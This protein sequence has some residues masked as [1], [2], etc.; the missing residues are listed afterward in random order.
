M[1]LVCFR[2]GPSPRQ[3]RLGAL[4]ADQTSVLDLTA[5]T[6]CR[7]AAGGLP[8]VAAARVAEA[9]T[10]P[11]LGAFV[12][13]GELGLE[14]AR[15][16][17]EWAAHSGAERDPTGE[18]VRYALSEVTRLAAVPEP[19]LIRDFMAFEQHL[20]NI[21][22]R[23]GREIPPEWY[24]IPAYYKG[25]PAAVGADGDDVVIPGYAG[26][27]LDFEFEFAAVIGR[28]GR[29]IDEADA[30]AHVYGYTIYDDFSARGMQS[31]EMAVGLGP[32][33]GKDFDGAHVLGPWLVTADEVPDPYVLS[34]TA[35]VNG[36]EW[37]TGSSADMHWRFEQMIAHASR[38]ETLR[39]LEV[40]GSGTV[41][42]GSAAE[43]GKTLRDG[44]TVELEV[45]RL[46]VLRNTVRATR[47]RH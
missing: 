46:G 21:Y 13:N 9:L 40:F 31:K 29:D 42:G 32:A 41:G 45:E 27:E 47:A 2:T 11:Q 24:E 6:A 36:Q 5:A 35:R 34:L 43:V 16:S 38:A 8:A 18:R 37:T 19:A 7:L 28:G 4:L 26:A 33:K 10:P 44:D 1:R 22:P 15:E 30:L 20:R 23:L 12:D 17:V 14:H 25:N 39:P 3:Q